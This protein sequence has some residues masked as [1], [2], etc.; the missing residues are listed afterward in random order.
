[1]RRTLGQIRT[2]FTESASA[3]VSAQ[4]TARAR[5]GIYIARVFV[6][7]VKQWARDRCPQQAAALAYQS[8]L[9]LVPLL[10]IAFALLRTVGSGDAQDRLL[11][12][13]T[14]EVLPDLEET[15]VHL[16][17]FSAKITIGA[18]GG[19]GLLITLFT[20]FSL[21]SSVEK[22]FNDIW[23]VEARRALLPRF[24]TF[25]ALVT[26]LPVA[27][28]SSLYLSGKL[29]GSSHVAQF[30]A[31]LA[32]QFLALFLLNKLLPNIVVRWQAALAGAI[33]SGLALEGLKWGFVQFAKRMLLESYAGV[34]GSLGLVPMLLLWIYLSWLLVL[35]GAEIAN[36][37][38]NLR[39]LEAED[40]RRTDQEP[41]NALVA[42]Q[43]LAFI[44]ANH[45]T[46]GRGVTREEVATEYGLT[47]HVV[48]R[49]VERLKQQGL[50]AEVVGDKLGL[51]P[52]RA[53]TAIS[54]ADVLAAFRATD[55]EVASG[56][57]SAA[58]AQ[59][60][61]DLEEGRR[62]R[63]EGL[64]LAE[65]LP[66]RAAGAAPREPKRVEIGGDGR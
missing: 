5:A 24:L 47:T 54:V 12:Y 25:Y 30:L 39:L 10:A 9:S 46:G 11:D 56:T 50:V 36:A 49:I 1:V 40:R 27:G 17:T 15:S 62:E 53:A 16:K 14:T 32:V 20:C 52:G 6:R 28:A 65:L 63:I 33:A 13:L 66:G 34:Y 42:T 7:I 60:V 29:V 51:I 43:L 19:A 41:I 58:L 26:L 45:E 57:T 59:L 44:A 21:Y 23:R 18:A 61:S 4:L 55:L 48:G 38:Q 22:I 3:A 8:A 37:L 35:F 2:Y 64:T 31:P